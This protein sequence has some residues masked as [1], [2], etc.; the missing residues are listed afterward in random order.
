MGENKMIAQ[1]TLMVLT[2]GTLFLIG[3]AVVATFNLIKKKLA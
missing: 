1:I 2:F 3:A